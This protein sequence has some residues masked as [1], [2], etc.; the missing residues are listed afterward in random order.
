MLGPGY[1]TR[2]CSV[3]KGESR[4]FGDKV[5]LCSIE[6]LILSPN[7]VLLY[8]SDTDIHIQFPPK[9]MCGK[10]ISVVCSIGDELLFAMVKDLAKTHESDNVRIYACVVLLR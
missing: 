2:I 4:T 9:D 6:D 5:R 10:L 3:E 1:K 7:R 8:E